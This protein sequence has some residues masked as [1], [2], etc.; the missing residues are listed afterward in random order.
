VGVAAVADLV[1]PAV[2]AAVVSGIVALVVAR[3]TARATVDAARLAATEERAKQC[4]AALV[5]A[6]ES[7]Q[8]ANLQEAEWKVRHENAGKSRAGLIEVQTIL[9]G[10]VKTNDFEQLVRLLSAE[11]EDDL[12]AAKDLWPSVQESIVGAL[13]D[14]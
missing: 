1:G 13:S 10:R 4:R 2:V 6:V 7:W 8:I 11:K 9:G 5:R 14:V 3:Y 12:N